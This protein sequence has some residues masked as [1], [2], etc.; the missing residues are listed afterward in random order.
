MSNAEKFHSVVSHFDPLLSEF[1]GK[2]GF[3]EL[4]KYVDAIGRFRTHPSPAM[5]CRCSPLMAKQP[6]ALTGDL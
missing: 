1:D 4:L 6:E 5:T 2:K 3:H